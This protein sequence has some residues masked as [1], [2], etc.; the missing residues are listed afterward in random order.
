MSN[1]WCV[2]EVRQLMK[3]RD[4]N[5]GFKHRLK[6]FLDAL[7]TEHELWGVNEVTNFTIVDDIAIVYES[8]YKE[9]EF[10]DSCYFTPVEQAQAPKKD[11]Q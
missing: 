8:V 11:Q 2:F 3:F 4:I 9:V 6:K 10:G 7:T 5:P 1:M